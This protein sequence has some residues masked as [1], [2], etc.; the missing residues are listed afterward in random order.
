MN[1]AET[2][3]LDQYSFHERYRQ[4]RQKRLRVGGTKQYLEVTGEFVKILEDW[5]A[6]AGMKRLE[7][8]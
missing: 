7:P 3:K 1:I 6:N 4:E 5:T 2:R 8:C